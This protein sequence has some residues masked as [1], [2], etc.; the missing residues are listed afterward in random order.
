M[1]NAENYQSHN[2]HILV[3]SIL[4]TPT[5]LSKN[6]HNRKDKCR[7]E[8]SQPTKLDREVRKKIK[9][10]YNQFCCQHKHKQTKN[11]RNYGCNQFHTKA[12]S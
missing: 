3:R 9:N 1:T 6:G 11:R 4:S 2:Y 10:S 12:L 8:H 7:Q 5:P